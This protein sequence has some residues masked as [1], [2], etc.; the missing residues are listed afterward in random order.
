MSLRS[1]W[2]DRPVYRA[3]ADDLRDGLPEKEHRAGGY[4]TFQAING[5][6]SR[7]VGHCVND[8]YLTQEVLTSLAKHQSERRQSAT[9]VK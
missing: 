3:A 6:C 9:K 8:W 4:F 1:R 2:A 5:T 7:A